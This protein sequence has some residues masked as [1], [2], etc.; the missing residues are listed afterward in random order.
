MIIVIQK[1]KIKQTEKCC[2]NAVILSNKEY[3]IKIK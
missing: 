3:L 2:Y 1:K